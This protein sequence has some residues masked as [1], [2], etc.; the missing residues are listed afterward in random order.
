[1]EDIL[2]FTLNTKSLS[3]FLL[4]INMAIIFMITQ[5]KG[6]DDESILNGLQNLQF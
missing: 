6:S 2:V 1:M 3:I 5:H 4:S